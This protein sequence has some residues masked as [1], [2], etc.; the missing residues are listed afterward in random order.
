MLPILIVHLNKKVLLRERKR[1][2]DRSV[3]STPYPVLP[4]GVGGRYLGVPH[5][6]LL[7]WMGRVGTL[8]VPPPPCSDLDG[9]VGTLDGGVGTLG[10]APS[11]PG[12]GVCTLGYPLPPVLTWTGGGRYLWWRG[13]RYLGVPPPPTSWPGQEGVGTLDGDGLDTLGVP[14]PPPGVDKLTNWNY[15]LPLILRMRSVTSSKNRTTEIWS[16]CFRSVMARS[17]V[18]K[19]KQSHCVY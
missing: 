13:G 12:W 10:Y 4:Q 11:W 18:N 19:A 16:G 8:G 1:H 14:P 2:T 7:T 17:Q 15:Y 5:P 6:S 9:G 3:W